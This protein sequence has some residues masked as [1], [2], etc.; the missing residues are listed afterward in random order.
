[1]HGS[2]GRAELFVLYVIAPRMRE[3]HENERIALQY[4]ADSASNNHREP[5]EDWFCTTESRY[6]TTCAVVSCKQY[7]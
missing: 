2:H 4:Y 7:L 5:Y 1:M 3:T 6:L